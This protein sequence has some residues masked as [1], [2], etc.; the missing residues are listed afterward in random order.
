[1]VPNPEIK[2][3][4][5]ITKEKKNTEERCPNPQIV[6]IVATTARNIIIITALVAWDQD[7]ILLW[8]KN[9]LLRFSQQRQHQRQPQQ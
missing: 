1:M 5:E 2:K 7:G 3:E 9:P 4:I 8:V 6:A